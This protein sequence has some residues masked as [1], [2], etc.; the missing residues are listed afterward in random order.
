MV[1]G[2]PCAPRGA[3]TV[4]EGVSNAGLPH[5]LAV[6]VARLRLL[7]SEHQ[8]NL[9]RLEDRL[10]RYFPAE[11]ARTEQT[12]QNFQSDMETLAQHPLPEKDFVGMEVMGKVYTDKAEAGKAL[13]ACGALA[14][15][16]HG[17]EIGH[18]RG[19][20]MCVAVNAFTKQIELTLKGSGSHVVELG[21]DIHGNLTRIENGLSSIP[22]RIKLLTDKLDTLHTQQAET[23]A[24]KDKPFPQ[25]AE[26]QQ[27][28]ARL[29][30]LDAELNIDKPPAAEPGQEN[31]R[32]R[33]S[34][35]AQLNTPGLFGRGGRHRDSQEE[36]L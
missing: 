2:E 10:A 11:I 22:S 28:S 30:E 5:D 6:E 4:L 25:E 34:I 14:T 12:I 27:K 26:L 13:I 32:G 17:T 20:S 29:A 7:K 19:L 36:C 3:C 18:Y 23:E 24:E 8:A 16:D 35:R 21:T 31:P 33:P 9:Y 1:N 15:V